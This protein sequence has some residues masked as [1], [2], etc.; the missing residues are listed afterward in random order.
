MF[1][2][3][4]PPTGK[5]AIFFENTRIEVDAGISVAAAVLHSD[6]PHSRRTGGTGTERNAYCCMGICYE[7]LMEI[8]GVPN[9]QSCMV[10]VREGMRVWRQ[11][12][13]P[14][15]VTAKASE[16]DSVSSKKGL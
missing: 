6:M 12:G 5:V 16:H 4:F 10:T 13:D 1:K 11:I 3:V 7:C 8:D 2:N 15:Y 14:N 9:Q